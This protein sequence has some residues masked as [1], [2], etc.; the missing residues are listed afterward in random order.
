[1]VQGSGAVDVALTE[2]DQIGREADGE[3]LAAIRRL[4]S[5]ARAST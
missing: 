1:M 5:V 4:D 2:I 3:L